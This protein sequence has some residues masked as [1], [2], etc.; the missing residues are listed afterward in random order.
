MQF[1]RIALASADESGSVRLKEAAGYPVEGVEGA[2][3]KA[4]ADAGGD[5]GLVSAR[6]PG[7]FQDTLR[8]RH[9]LFLLLVRAQGPGRVG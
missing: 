9:E 5:F 8:H 6:R 1:V 4:T 2:P 7:V 3:A